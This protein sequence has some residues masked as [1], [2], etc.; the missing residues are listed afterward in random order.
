MTVTQFEPNGVLKM[1][2]FLPRVALDASQYDVNYVFSLE[3]NN[4]MVVLHFEI[5]DFSPLPKAQDY[6][7]AS[8]EFV[9]N[10]KSKIKT[11]AEHG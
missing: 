9:E 1:N 5:I 2:L 6:Y 4:A 7:E 10:A 3:P 11:L 8:L